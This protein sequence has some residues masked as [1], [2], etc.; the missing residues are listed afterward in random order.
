MTGG[1]VKVDEQYRI[2]MIDLNNLG[3]LDA[4]EHDPKINRFSVRGL[5]QME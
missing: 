1:R 5:M 3:Y 4:N 2:T